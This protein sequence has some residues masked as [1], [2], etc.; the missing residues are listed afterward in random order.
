MMTLRNFKIA[1]SRD[2]LLDALKENRKKHLED[3]HTAMRGFVLR[4]GQ[5]IE[6]LDLQLQS[7]EAKAVDLSDVHSLN[8]PL[9]FSHVYDQVIHMVEFSEDQTFQLDADQFSAWVDNKWEW[10]RAWRDQNTIYLQT[11]LGTTN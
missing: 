3:W 1:V 10:D 4:A 5:V 7:K 6:E 8:K 2:K 9:C 11:A